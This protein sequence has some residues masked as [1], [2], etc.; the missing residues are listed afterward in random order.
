MATRWDMD[1][2]LCMCAGCHFWSHKNPTLFTEFVMEYLGKERYENLKQRA[3][4]IRKWT[5][6][7]MIEFERHIH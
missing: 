3:K 7:E 4:S 5:L 1:N 2:L 6:E